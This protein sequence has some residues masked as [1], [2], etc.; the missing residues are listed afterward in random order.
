MLSKGSV[1]VLFAG[2]STVYG[3]SYSQ[4]IMAPV[5]VGLHELGIT[6]INVG[7]NTDVTGNGRFLTQFGGTTATHSV[8][9]I[10]TRELVDGVTNGGNLDAGGTAGATLQPLATSLTAYKPDL[11]V[12]AVGTNDSYNG[13]ITQYVRLIRTIANYSPD[14]PVLWITPAD[15]NGTANS[16]V[17]YDSSRA[18]TKE[19]IRSA[20]TT[21]Q[22]SGGALGLLRNLML[23]D[24]Q[25]AYTRI[26]RYPSK[27]LTANH[28]VANGM[29]DDGTHLKMEGS[30][31]WAAAAL[32]QGFGIGQSAML[33]L[34]CQNEPYSP[35]P[36]EYSA[37]VNAG[38]NAVM[39]AGSTRKNILL[40]LTIKNTD[41]ANLATA[42]L[43]R[44]RLPQAQLDNT[45]TGTDL[46][47]DTA[48][49]TTFEIPAGGS[50]TRGFAASPLVAWFN[51]GW[52]IAIA[53]GNCNVE[54]T[55]IQALYWDRVSA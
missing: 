31:V 18:A 40:S 8:G 46:G 21:T 53:G 44:R 41:T 48:A 2:D 4:G 12:M 33:K 15:S 11:I 22:S 51:D 17:A 16:Y 27:D 38:S 39:V 52:K 30:A 23:I 45:N 20:M 10:R 14:V 24:G 43:Y 37:N 34:I 26:A 36:W 9:G 55:G 3:S 28:I 49:L 19:A 32:G 6:P 7:P 29:F 5:L 35:L 1:K 54:A 50:I 42:T 13:D 47:A 25:Q